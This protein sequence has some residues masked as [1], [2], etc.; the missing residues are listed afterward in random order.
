MIYFFFFF[1]FNNYQLKKKKRLFNYRSINQLFN[2]KTNIL[3]LIAGLLYHTRV[4]FAVFLYDVVT[5]VGPRTYGAATYWSTR[6]L[7]LSLSL[8]SLFRLIFCVVL[9]LNYIYVYHFCRHVPGRN[10]NAYVRDGFVRHVYWNKE[11]ERKG[12]MA[13]RVKLVWTL[14]YEGKLSEAFYIW[15]YIFRN[16]NICSS[17]DID[18]YCSI[19]YSRHFQHGLRRNQFHKP[20]RKSGMQ[21]WWYFKWECWRS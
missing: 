20:N 19:S 15:T 16:I 1:F 14:L 13:F 4:I 11:Y 6:S 5:E 10:R 8:S 17:N 2:N 3:R 12:S 21:W 9:L 7:S 18:R